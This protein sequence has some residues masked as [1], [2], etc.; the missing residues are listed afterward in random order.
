MQQIVDETAFEVQSSARLVVVVA[1]HVD[2]YERLIPVHINP[3]F[4]PAGSGEIERNYPF[5]K[6]AFLP[7]VGCI[8]RIPPSTLAGSTRMN[9]DKAS[10]AFKGY[11]ERDF[12]RSFLVVGFFIDRSLL[13]WSKLE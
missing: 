10:S 8:Q 5:G 9:S 11:R 6:A 13:L 2:V 4:Q 12:K 3:Q 1:D 7:L